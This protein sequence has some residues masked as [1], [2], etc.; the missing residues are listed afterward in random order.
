MSLEKNELAP[1]VVSPALSGVP[2]EI[3]V[4]AFAQGVAKNTDEL[5]EL[6]GQVAALLAI[7]AAQNTVAPTRAT[8]KTKTV[9]TAING[10]LDTIVTNTTP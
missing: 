5:T 3:G 9:D 4:E 10:K 2:L 1:C 8:T 7:V 6:K